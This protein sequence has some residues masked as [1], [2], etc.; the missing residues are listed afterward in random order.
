M[1][2]YEIPNAKQIKKRLHCLPE[3]AEC[4]FGSFSIKQE[5]GRIHD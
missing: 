4:S 2:S 5:Q 1:L 3:K